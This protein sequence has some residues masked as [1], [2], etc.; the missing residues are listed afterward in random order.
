MRSHYGDIF[1]YLGL[2]FEPHSWGFVW[3]P[4]SY[5]LGPERWWSIRE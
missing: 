3:V 5:R 2:G 4:V 1:A